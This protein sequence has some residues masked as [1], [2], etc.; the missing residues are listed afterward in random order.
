MRLLQLILSE[1]EE[2][3]KNKKERAEKEKRKWKKECERVN[4]EVETESS[5]KKMNEMDI[6]VDNHVYPIFPCP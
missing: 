3:K 6:H 2:V 1:E 4:G 5:E